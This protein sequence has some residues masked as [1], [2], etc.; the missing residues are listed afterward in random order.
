MNG[1]ILINDDIL[2]FEK[3]GKIN[4]CDIHPGPRIGLLRPALPAQGVAWIILLATE[5][6]HHH[7]GET[8][9]ADRPT[10]DIPEKNNQLNRQLREVLSISQ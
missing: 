2:N 9:S 4:F 6:A 7:V 10:I 3:S 5:T 8:P 1:L